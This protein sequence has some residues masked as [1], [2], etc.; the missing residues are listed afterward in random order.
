V[1]VEAS[2]VIQDKVRPSVD[3][4]IE[5]EAVYAS[6]ETAQVEAK[7]V[8]DVDLGIV[9][10]ECMLDVD[11]KIAYASKK[12]Q[13]FDK[14]SISVYPGLC[15]V[16]ITAPDHKPLTINIF[17]EAR[18]SLTVPIRLEPLPATVIFEPPSADT[19]IFVDQ[20]QI[21]L[22]GLRNNI[23]VEPGLRE[24]VVLR[25]GYIPLI[26]ERNF[27]ANETVP[28]SM[29]L[30]K[31]EQLKLIGGLVLSCEEQWSSLKI[32]GKYVE[33]MPDE[34]VYLEPG[35]HV[36]DT[37][38]GIESV[39]YTI[40][41]KPGETRE[42][43]VERKKTEPIFA[44]KY[45]LIPEGKATVGSN[46]F[47]SDNPEKQVILKEYWVQKNEVTVDEYVMCVEDGFCARIEGRGSVCNSKVSGRGNHPINCITPGE[48]ET[49]AG[50]L[51][52]RDE[53]YVYRLPSTEEW[54]RS[55]RSSAGR[56]YPWGNE[57]NKTIC[58]T[59][60]VNCIYTTWSD[61]SID[62]GWGNTSPVGVFTECRTE[63]G[64]WDIIGNVAEMTRSGIDKRY[65]IKGGSWGHGEVFLEPAYKKG[66]GT[67]EYD[68]RV[69]FRLVA[70]SVSG[71][72]Y[73][74][75]VKE[76][77]PGQN[78]IQLPEG[79]PAVFFEKG[80]EGVFKKKGY[81]PLEYTDELITRKGGIII[82]SMTGD[83]EYGWYLAGAIENDN[84]G[85]S[86]WLARKRGNGEILWERRMSYHDKDSV[87][88]DVQLSPDGNAVVAGF[89]RSKRGG[90]ERDGWV[91]KVAA[92]GGGVW[93][94]IYDIESDELFNSIG[95]FEDGNM[96]AVG[97]VSMAGK[98]RKALVVRLN[99]DG[100]IIWQRTYGE[101]SD[102]V[103]IS[104]MTQGDGFVFSGWSENKQSDK[105]DA[106][107][108]N[109]DAWGN[110]KWDVVWDGGSDDILFSQIRTLDGYYVAVGGS[111]SSEI[112]SKAKSKS[113]TGKG[114]G[115][116]LLIDDKGTVVSSSIMGE[117]GS[118]FYKVYLS[119]DGELISAGVTSGGDGTDKDGWLV[120]LDAGA[121]VVRQWALHR[122]A[123][124]KLYSVT[125][126]ANGHI[127]ATG[128][129]GNPSGNELCGWVVDIDRLRLKEYEGI[130]SVSLE[131][132]VGCVDN[133]VCVDQ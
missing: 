96:L 94:R 23:T 111:A 8:Y 70:T 113:E 116:V 40:F 66:W 72:E 69:G 126:D 100:Q 63:E 82:Y 99:E 81:G 9:V 71:Q 103:A 1:A 28:V 97:R 44:G 77:K 42:L 79:Y 74:R 92:H 14:R 76:A 24:I 86:G 30:S 90:G 27:S 65:E 37:V 6:G 46:S 13:T 133:E 16:T 18:A 49:Y 19:Q 108:V 29:E 128:H 56:K 34:F 95:I 60:D 20:Q 89:T 36:I 87:L 58:N 32:D 119:E 127:I 83:G 93:S 112:R 61:R 48:A 50:W 114:K 35:S 39:S 57:L 131:E 109:A 3:E 4:S 78:S 67:M 122:S 59:C 75:I 129:S 104:V 11:C 85:L 105:M 110:K 2:C 124:D 38:F 41:L 22:S 88:K 12:K 33:L 7:S 98:G 64:V 106:W 123:M 51:S 117:K 53:E 26:I 25:D 118:R 55:A 84:G 125:I 121:N 62:D 31:N 45:I 15:E 91:A 120:E 54:E 68:P 47:P 107:V 102:K 5:K 10:I 17:V 21:N 130:G 73:E 115:L 43:I 52:M 132:D 80:E 101:E